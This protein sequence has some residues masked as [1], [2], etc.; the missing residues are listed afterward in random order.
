MVRFWIKVY[1]FKFKLKVG[2]KFKFDKK[3]KMSLYNRIYVW[4]LLCSKVYLV[5]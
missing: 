1:E 2:L 5:K 4:I 3:K